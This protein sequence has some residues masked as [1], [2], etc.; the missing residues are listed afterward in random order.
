M[1][2]KIPEATLQ[3]IRDRVSIVEVVSGYVA[4][5][6]AGRNYVG[7]CPFHTEKTPS[8]TVSE[9]R[10]FFH[11]FGC[12]AGGSVFAFLMRIERLDFPQAVEAV[13]RRAGIELPAHRAE[14]AAAQLRDRWV[15]LNA[16]AAE[17]FSRCLW[18]EA[19]ARARRY[20][21]QRG[22]AE[23][24]AR[25]FRLGY[26]PA[27]GDWLARALE[28][29]AEA[30]AAAVRVGLLARRESG[31]PYD[32]FRDRIVFP[33]PD[34]RGAIVGFGARTLGDTQPKYLNSP[35]SPLFR[36]GEVLYGLP[37][38]RAAGGGAASEVVVVE[39]YMDVLALFQ[40]GIRNAVATLGTALTA[41]HLRLLKRIAPRIVVFFDGDRAGRAAALRAFGVCA[42][43]GI[44]ASAAFLPEG[45]DPDSFV[46]QRGAEATRALLD[47]AV[48][49]S[50]F[51]LDEM[52]Q[53]SLQAP[54]E[55][56]AQIAAEVARSLR[57]VRDPIHRDVLVHAAAE[58]LAIGEDA[59][60]A[61]AVG[62]GRDA[63]AP[64]EAAVKTEPP[65]GTPAEVQLLEAMAQSREIA[66]WVCEQKPDFRS[67]DLARCAARLAQAWT[68]GPPA[69]AAVLDELP[70]A[71]A[72]RI[73]AASLGDETDAWQVARD[74]VERLREEAER[75][76][77]EA[78]LAELRGLGAQGDPQRERELL[79][80][81]QAA[82]A[83]KGHGSA[84]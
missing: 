31:G 54:I 1:S 40:H 75:P 43:A 9:E 30:A 47:C 56:R 72:Q 28:G 15:Q 7:L 60:R 71:L 84:P 45:D 52:R 12:G 69:V 68:H 11:C 65:V 77:R 22:I 13:A 80:R 50:D 44:W 32:W 5:R 76:V 38:V 8:F 6:R 55:E 79:R 59:L 82:F 3:E 36:K 62:R 63:F 24:T 37:H 81:A 35:E 16:W 26:A 21:Q 49:I 64:R 57:R 83:R 20:L 48:P 51:Y 14:P 66:R 10:G 4:L 70:E 58:R 53:R 78:V 29:R 23:E 61:V 34:S 27:S 46:R 67:P 73:R 33:I 74:C 19:G 39:G 42:E 41:S 17:K 25:A 18:S 2:W